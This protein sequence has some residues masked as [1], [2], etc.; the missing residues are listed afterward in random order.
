[1]KFVK[2]VASQYFQMIMMMMMM[3]LCHRWPTKKKQ[4]TPAE[5]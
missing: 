1:M 4:N 5:E 3:V 2:L